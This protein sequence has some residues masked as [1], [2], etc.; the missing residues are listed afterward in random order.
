MSGTL[1]ATEVVEG[2]QSI[3]SD[4]SRHPEAVPEDISDLGHL[5]GGKN[6]YRD[7]MRRL[8]KAESPE[9]Y[10]AFIPGWD[11]HAARQKPI[12]VNFLLPHEVLDWLVRPRDIHLW[13]RF[14]DGQRPQEYSLREWGE[15]VNPP[16]DALA[17]NVISLG[18]WGD[19]APYAHRD[20]LYL[21]TWQTISGSILRHRRNW[22]C[23]FPKRLRG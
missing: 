17:E 19:A 18:I 9:V 3:C 10:Q 21:L 13:S 16:L 23:G 20:S 1:A 8:D 12:L 6:S 15:N 11:D 2:A 7:V 14:G 22:F 5:G 4:F